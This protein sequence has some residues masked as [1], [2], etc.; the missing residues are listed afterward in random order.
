LKVCAVFAIA[1]DVIPRHG[2]EGPIDG[3]GRSR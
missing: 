1:D 3:A 2:G